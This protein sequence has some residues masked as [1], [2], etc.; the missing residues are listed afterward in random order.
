MHRLLTMRRLSIMFVSLFA[1]A[2]AGMLSYQHFRLDPERKCAKNGQ[3][4][5]AEERRCV[6]PVYIPE[7]TGR[8]PGV[9]REQASRERNAEVYRLE[10][11]VRREKAR[12]A[13]EAA[14]QRRAL[15]AAESQK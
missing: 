14:E 11:D 4:Y 5:F 8:T 6:T 3:W 2:T 1:V 13:H 9:S 7:I 15:V 10:E 12:L